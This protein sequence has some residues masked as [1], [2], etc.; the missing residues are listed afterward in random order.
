MKSIAQLLTEGRYALGVMPWAA[1][2]ME[3]NWEDIE[4]KL[5]AAGELLEAV[6]AARGWHACDRDGCDVP[7]DNL[8]AIWAAAEKLRCMK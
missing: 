7:A 2:F 3:D 6:D 5:R 1:A 4:A 8:W